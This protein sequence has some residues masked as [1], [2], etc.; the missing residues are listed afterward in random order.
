MAR[1][2]RAR[3]VELPARDDV[4]AAADRRGGA[5]RHRQPSRPLRR[6]RRLRGREGAH[7]RARRHAGAEPR[8]SAVARDA[9]SRPHGR[10][11]RRRRARRRKASGASSRFDG[12]TWLAR[13]GGLLVPTVGAGARRP[14]QRAE[15]ARGAG[16]RVDGRAH[17]PPRARRAARVR[18]ACRTG[19]S[20]SPRR[21]ASL[22]IDDSKGTTVAA[23][24]AALDGIG[25][26]VVLI[27]GGDG[28][29]QDF[30]PLTAAVDARLP[31]GAADRPRRA[32]DRAR[33]RRDAGAASRTSARSTPPSTRA[34][35]LA[36]P[37]DAVL[38]SPACA[39]LDQFANY[40]ERG[41]R[42]A[43]LVRDASGGATPMRKRMT[44]TRGRFGMLT[45]SALARRAAARPA[46]DARPTTRRSR[47]PRCCCSRSAS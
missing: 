31:R 42:F 20:A 23:T 7:L 24:Q 44:P 43:A 38:L 13:G 39:S 34:I 21:A 4:V 46:H 18:R 25:R 28:K 27:A 17:R 12:A 1:R 5:Q 6:H 30:A 19:C 40:V 22:F 10:D 16:A 41:E 2:L 32:A 37:G 36:E 47:G 3:A 8:R 14:A 26:P 15:R 35:A 45:A 33:A 11:V 9:H 29:G